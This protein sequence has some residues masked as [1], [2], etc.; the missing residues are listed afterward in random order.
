MS[1]GVKNI[2]S[3]DTSEDVANHA[4]D[5]VDGKDIKTVIDVEDELELGGK[6]A[7]DTTADTDDD[8]SP[9]LDEASSRGDGNETRDGT[10][11]ETDSAPLLLETVIEKSPG[12]GTAR[13]GKVGHVAGHD[14]AN[15]HAESRTTVEAEPT[16]PEEDGAEH[17]VGDVV[18]TVGETV[19][20]RVTSTLAEHQGVGEGASSR[21]NVNG[22]A[23]SK[24]VAGEVEQPTVTVPGPVGNGV[25][26]NG[27]PEEHEDHGREDTATISN[28]T[29]SEGRTVQLAFP[30]ALFGERYSRNAG[31]HA[32]VKAQQDIRKERRSIGLSQSLHETELGEVAQE[33]VSSSR[34]GQGVAPEEPLEADDGDRGHGQQNQRQGRLA[35]GEAAVEEADAGNHEKNQDSGDDDEGQVPGLEPAC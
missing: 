8:S 12:N 34:K 14:G 26:D 17:D 33:G 7:K 13:G 29:N 18:R 24:V 16:D 25:V 15:V 5:T 9:G 19:V 11:A 20:A 10:R 28:G 22:T 31:K 27:R 2:R 1:Q 3:K 6:V 35:T 32:L 23:T 4:A 21:S 30:L